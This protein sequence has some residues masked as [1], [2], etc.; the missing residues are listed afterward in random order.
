M[1]GATQATQATL[2]LEAIYRETSL[3]NKSTQYP[4]GQQLLLGP[5]ALTLN[6]TNLGWLNLLL[7]WQASFC[8]ELVTLVTQDIAHIDR[9]LE[10]MIDNKKNLVPPKNT[11]AR[12][13]PRQ[14]KLC[15]LP[16]H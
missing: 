15:I 12:N 13:T 7:K 5:L 9:E 8:W 3:N 10:V 16:C 11:N 1:V 4:L 2:K 6:A 14:R